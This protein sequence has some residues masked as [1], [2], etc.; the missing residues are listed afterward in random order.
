[1][2]GPLATKINTG[3]FQIGAGIAFRVDDKVYTAVA[4]AGR[5]NA[6]QLLEDLG[7][8]MTADGRTVVF[9]NYGSLGSLRV[10]G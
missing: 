6:I 1:M 5:A 4:R 2:S 3:D 9:R 10:T 8:Q 7:N